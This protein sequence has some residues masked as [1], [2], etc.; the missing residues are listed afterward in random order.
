LYFF[1]LLLLTAK[2]NISADHYLLFDFPGQVE[3]FFLHSNARSVINKLI[4]KM[5]LRVECALC[6]I[7]IILMLMN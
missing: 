1:H 5:D 4:K 3:L 2:L 6:P 7:Y